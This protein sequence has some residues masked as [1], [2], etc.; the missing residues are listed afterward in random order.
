VRAARQFPKSK[1]ETQL[2][3]KNHQDRE[4]VNVAAN[5]AA[6]RTH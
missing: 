3:A 1:I 6:Q 4:E 2:L 5:V